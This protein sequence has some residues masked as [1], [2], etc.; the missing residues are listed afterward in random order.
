MLQAWTQLR[1]LQVTLP[2]A[3]AV[4]AAQLFP[5]EFVLVLPFTT[6]LLP[7]AWKPR[8][9]R[10]PQAKGLPAQVAE[11]LPAGLGHGPHELPQLS[12]LVSDRQLLPQ[13]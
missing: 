3:G 11:P 13:R 6:Q 5:Q 7:Q 2:L 4:Q 8:S 9:Q 10:T 12:V 1:P